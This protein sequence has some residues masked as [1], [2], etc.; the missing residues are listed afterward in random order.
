MKLFAL[1][2][3]FSLF[4]CSK[5]CE[6][7]ASVCASCVLEGQKVPRVV[8]LCDLNG[9]ACV[10]NETVSAKVL[11]GDNDDDD[12]VL[13]SVDGTKAATFLVQENIGSSDSPCL[14]SLAFNSFSNFDVKG[15]VSAKVV[16][17]T[18]SGLTTVS[19]QLYAESYAKV[20]SKDVRI[21]G[22]IEVDGNG[23]KVKSCRSEAKCAHPT[24]DEESFEAA[25]KKLCL[26]DAN[27]NTL[28][29]SVAIHAESLLDTSNG[30]VSS[31]DIVL[32]ASSIVGNV[33]T[34]ITA[35]SKSF[36]VASTM[37]LNGAK[38]SSDGPGSAS[39]GARGG[40]V[41]FFASE[42]L[43]ATSA[44]F[45]ANGGDGVVC[46]GAGGYVNI[47]SAHVTGLATA[48]AQGGSGVKSGECG[49]VNLTGCSP[50]AALRPVEDVPCECGSPFSSKN[51]GYNF[52][53]NCD[54]GEA[55]VSD[56]CVECVPGSIAPKSGEPQCLP[57]GKGKYQTYERAQTCSTCPVGKYNAEVLC[58]GKL[59]CLR[60]APRPR[61]STFVNVSGGATE[62][63]CP[64]EC[65]EGLVPPKCVNSLENLLG[66]FFGTVQGII[67]T[68]VVI[69]LSGITI[70]VLR[71]ARLRQR[72]AKDN[73]FHSSEL[74]RFGWKERNAERRSSLKRN[75]SSERAFVCRLYL[76]GSNGSNGK[77]KWRLGDSQ[78]FHTLAK[79][80]AHCRDPQRA[81]D[82]LKG[83]LENTE[84]VEAISS[85]R[86]G[87]LFEVIRDMLE[88]MFMRPLVHLFRAARRKRRAAKIAERFRTH[89]FKCGLAFKF[90]CT[91][92]FRVAYV[93]AYSQRSQSVTTT[94]P[95]VILFGGNGSYHEPFYLDPNDEILREIPNLPQIASSFID[96]PLVAF[97][98]DV[99]VRVR[100]ITQGMLRSKLLKKSQAKEMEELS[101][102][103]VRVE[104]T[105]G[106]LTVSF[107]VFRPHQRSLG[108]TVADVSFQPGLLLRH[109]DDNDDDD[110]RTNELAV[111]K[112][113]SLATPKQKSAPKDIPSK[114]L[115]KSKM[116]P[117]D[118]YSSL[119]SLS[120]NVLAPMTPIG[121]PIERLKSAR[122]HPSSPLSRSQSVIRREALGM[123][124]HE[125][126]RKPE[127]EPQRI[128]LE[129]P[130]RVMYGPLEFDRAFPCTAIIFC[131]NRKSALA[132][133]SSKGR[134]EL[135]LPETNR[136]SLL[137]RRGV[138]DFK[139][140]V[141]SL[142]AC[143]F[144]LIRTLRLLFSSNNIFKLRNVKP[145]RPW[146]F[147]RSLTSSE[148]CDVLNL[149]LMI[150]NCCDGLLSVIMISGIYCQVD[151]DPD[152]SYE[153]SRVTFYLTMLLYPAALLLTP[154]LG[155][156]AIGAWKLG[157]MRAY[158][159]FIRLSVI[160]CLFSVGGNIY[161][162]ATTTTMQFIVCASVLLIKLLQLE[163]SQQFLAH[164]ES[165]RTCRG[166]RGLHHHNSFAVEIE[167]ARAPIS[168][169]AEAAL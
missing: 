145:E 166:F 73:A 90:G 71:S 55:P 104:G 168:S 97:V 142:M 62:R 34:R 10:V 136:T 101:S 40:T 167:D 92:D 31:S 89:E 57:C 79:L 134:M 30:K 72:L 49:T 119:A 127:S 88:N 7:D 60:C 126:E 108:N 46:G 51:K 164:K 33:M 141:T 59:C 64:Y 58:V 112:P 3:L 132:P 123:D 67:V 85:V 52:C 56:E 147:P 96:E 130:G 23:E 68:T 162:Y 103:L 14:L 82:E 13:C 158:S 110:V 154:L 114:D 111:Y 83:V 15:K 122:L 137:S 35:S 81:L 50:G 17:V 128:E 18:A 95:M 26:V 1:V 28:P 93:D 9:T 76:H 45:R 125:T 135:R 19:G 5:A 121:T 66:P 22:T 163:I 99:N 106:E 124:L 70:S 151:D 120:S 27:I 150:N 117:D 153:C 38:I 74:L 77:G 21:S 78:S 159:D 161:F 48:S 169:N 115:S 61:S 133:S 157:F 29:F 25:T 80:R 8:K 16:N 32:C 41:Y 129:G 116:A 146:W 131:K 107:G 6:T 42:K 140:G 87:H 156:V 2:A 43:N 44:E 139:K 109:I 143:I 75:A 165:S 105:L 20:K 94:L 86:R 39:Y 98:N 138:R 160:N 102:Y 69:M 53:L 36:A 47:N 144:T 91:S 113:P 24:P 4:A 37:M 54:I 11:C 84:N 149:C 100:C 12:E 63:E 118:Q 148:Y 65:A 152:D 155:F